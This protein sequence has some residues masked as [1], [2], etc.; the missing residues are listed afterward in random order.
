MTSNINTPTSLSV[1]TL[2]D[3]SSTLSEPEAK[4]HVTLVLAW[5]FVIV[6]LI[7]G[8]YESAKLATLLINAFTS[9]P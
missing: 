7:W 3:H 9:K 6:P 8:I 1:A 5:T 2:S 4:S